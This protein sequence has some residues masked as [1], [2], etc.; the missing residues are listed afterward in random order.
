MISNTSLPLTTT[1]I[2]ALCAQAIRKI[3]VGWKKDPEQYDLGL[4]RV[5][6]EM[7]PTVF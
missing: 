6:M 4:S 5:L 2:A 3:E 1:Q 7:L